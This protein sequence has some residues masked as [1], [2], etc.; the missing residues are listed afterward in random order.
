MNQ[1]VEVKEIT[2]ILQKLS[3]FD[4]KQFLMK[5]PGSLVY[6]IADDM[7]LEYDREGMLFPIINKIMAQLA[8]NSM[9]KL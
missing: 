7:K 3:P 1:T 5:T 8:R 6:M 4:R 9:K 2:K